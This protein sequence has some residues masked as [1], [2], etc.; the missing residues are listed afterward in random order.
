MWLIPCNPVPLQGCDAGTDVTRLV[1]HLHRQKIRVTETE[2]DG[3]KRHRIGC[4]V[5]RDVDPHSVGL[6]GMAVVAAV[7]PV[8]TLQRFFPG[9]KIELK[10]ADA[11][12]NLWHVFLEVSLEDDLGSAVI[13]VEGDGASLAWG[14][15]NGPL[16]PHSVL[17][18]H[19][20]RHTGRQ[21]QPDRPTNTQAG[22]QTEGQ[23]QRHTPE[24]RHR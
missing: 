8:G 15:G 14:R 12:D 22:W 16:A 11:V 5:S 4:G 9:L 23:T 24:D 13:S 6:E 10:A 17:G 18:R 21:S 3:V 1:I 7:G 19:A 2:V 20:D